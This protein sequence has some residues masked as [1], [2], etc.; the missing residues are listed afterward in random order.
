MDQI[1]RSPQKAARVQPTYTEPATSYPSFNSSPNQKVPEYIDLEGDNNDTII[2]QQ[3]DETEIEYA[4]SGRSR[5]RV[6]KPNMS[7]KAL[8]NIENTT[9]K[10]SRPKKG[11]RDPIA[12]L[13]GVNLTPVVSKRTEIRQEIASKTAAYRN[14]FFVEKKDLFLPLLP[15]QHNYVKKLVEKHEQM[16]PEEIA[17]LPTINPYKEIETQPRGIKATMKPYQL[18]GLSFMMYLHRNVCFPPMISDGD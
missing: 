10:R 3:P 8:E 4:P 11:G 14:R 2:V 12:D 5:L 15:P 17:Q 6:R 13:A 1:N 9:P 18:S 7:L 16:T